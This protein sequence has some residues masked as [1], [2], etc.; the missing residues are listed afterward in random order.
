VLEKKNKK[1]NPRPSATI[2]SNLFLTV[3]QLSCDLE[4]SPLLFAFRKKKTSQLLIFFFVCVG[5]CECDVLGRG[6]GSGT[7]GNVTAS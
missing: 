2:A 3:G 7:E 6:T 1:K 5:V 4:L